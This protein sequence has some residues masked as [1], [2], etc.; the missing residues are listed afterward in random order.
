MLRLG[1][2]D[3]G[4][5][6]TEKLLAINSYTR[7]LGYSPEQLPFKDVAAPVKAAEKEFMGFSYGLADYDTVENPTC[8]VLPHSPY[9]R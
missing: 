9:R 2:E 4:T 6:H 5:C 3:H 1:G 7:S 8:P